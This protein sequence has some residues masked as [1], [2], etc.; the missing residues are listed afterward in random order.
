MTMG[1]I[2]L[3]TFTPSHRAAPVFVDDISIV[4]EGGVAEKELLS[5]P[6]EPSHRRLENLLDSEALGLGRWLGSLDL[7]RQSDTTAIVPIGKG[8][9][10]RG[11]CAD[12]GKPC[13]RSWM[14]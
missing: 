11:V 4:K 2:D 13:H 8:R 3:H 14:D 7:A 1:C 6:K 5:S 10:D 9:L 12:E